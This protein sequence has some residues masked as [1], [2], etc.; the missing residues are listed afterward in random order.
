MFVALGA[1]LTV[2]V[3]GLGAWLLVRRLGDVVV[4]ADTTAPQR[5]PFTGGDQ[6]R[7][8]LSRP[9]SLSPPPHSWYRH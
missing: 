8:A 4:P 5:V 9:S 1:A 7:P 3:A 2:F 6:S